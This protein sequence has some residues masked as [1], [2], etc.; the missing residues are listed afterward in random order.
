[1]EESLKAIYFDTKSPG[2]FGGVD[3]LQKASKCSKKK[4]EKWL[5]SEDVYTL[6][7][8]IKRRFKRRRVIVGG[9]NQQLQGDLID[10]QKLKKS[11][12]GV[13]FLLTLIDVFSRYASV[14]PLKN[15]KGESL[16]K[17]FKKLFK[18]HPRMGF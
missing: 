18:R 3:R 6:H 16:S 7:K 14:F 9:I 15:K 1:M 8:P 4:V 2:G 10:L 13:S 12:N 5:S 17:A 11:N